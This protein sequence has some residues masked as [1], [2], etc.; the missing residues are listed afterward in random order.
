MGRNAMDVKDGGPGT[1]INIR[2]VAGLRDAT[3]FKSKDASS[4]ASRAGGD[5][6]CERTNQVILRTLSEVVAPIRREIMLKGAA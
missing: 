6:T 3:P 1:T 5:R 2:I 4:H